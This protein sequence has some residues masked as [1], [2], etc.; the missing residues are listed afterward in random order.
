MRVSEAW[1]R[2]ATLPASRACAG[3][4]AALSAPGST[5]FLTI[6][7]L[8][9]AGRCGLD[10]PDSLHLTTVEKD[11]HLSFH[12]RDHWGPDELTVLWV[13]GEDSGVNDL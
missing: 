13:E 6:G 9:R 5:C 8:Q 2:M 1:R 3:G 7:L 12:S 11:M 4:S 10:G